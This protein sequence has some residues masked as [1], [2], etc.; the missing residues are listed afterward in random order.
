MAN[1]FV[2]TIYESIITPKT[3]IDDYFFG[4][5]LLD[6]NGNELTT[7]QISKNITRATD[8]VQKKLDILIT[9]V[10]FSEDNSNAERIDYRQADFV[11]WMHIKL[12]N[13]P[14]ISV[15]S[16][17]VKFPTDT[18]L[19]TYP[20]SWIR[21]DS[22]VGIVRLVPEV[23]SMPSYFMQYGG[24]LPEFIMAKDMIPHMLQVEYTAGFTN[25]QIPLFINELIGKKAAILLFSILGDIVLGAGIANQSVSID[26]LSVSTGTT[27]SAMY[28]AYSARVTQYKEELKDD[29]KT[30]LNYYKG[31]RNLSI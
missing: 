28:N 6:P 19:V 23:G 25:D 24:F 7:T 26:G 20:S 17:K 3:L 22:D 4:A 12:L 13:Y 21:L 2:N 10:E 11:N 14:V 16:V 15:E 8:W 9:P 18:D 29:M 5:S 30:A 31:I 27:A 1:E